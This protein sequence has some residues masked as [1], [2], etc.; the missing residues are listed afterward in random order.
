MGFFS[1]LS[2]KTMFKLHRS[3]DWCFSK[4][5]V[6]HQS[7]LRGHTRHYSQTAQCFTR[8]RTDQTTGTSDLCAESATH[9]DLSMLDTFTGRG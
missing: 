8:V 1:F 5:V 4:T 9:I 7:L 3:N 2:F 6:Q